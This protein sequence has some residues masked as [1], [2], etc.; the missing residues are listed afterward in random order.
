MSA[1]LWQRGVSGHAFTRACVALQA[2]KYALT[3][4]AL[5]GVA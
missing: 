4:I 3:A 1:C 5:G 2:E